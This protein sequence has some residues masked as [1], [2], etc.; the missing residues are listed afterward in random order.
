MDLSSLRI[1]VLHL[2]PCGFT[3][4]QPRGVQNERD[5]PVL[6]RS[7]LIQKPTHLGLAENLG[8]SFLAFWPRDVG[9]RG[10]RIQ[11]MPVQEPEGTQRL[12]GI[13]VRQS[14][15]EHI[16]H[17]GADLPVLGHRIRT[18]SP[19]IEPSHVGR[20]RRPRLSH[21]STQHQ[22]VVQPLQQLPQ[23]VRQRRSGLRIHRTPR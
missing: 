6:R 17:P 19:G 21:A 4:P 15:P 18:R 20:V 7:E 9:H 13:A 11:D 16:Q 10:G 5:R 8:Q 14:R 2:Q 22:L 12:V 1:D 23:P 3:D